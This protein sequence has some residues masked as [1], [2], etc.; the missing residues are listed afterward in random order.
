[1]DLATRPTGAEGCAARA[2]LVLDPEAELLCPTVARVAAHPRPVVWLSGAAVVALGRTAPGPQPGT[3]GTVGRTRAWGP[4]AP[5]PVARAAVVVRLAH[6]VRTGAP[7]RVEVAEAALALLA[8]GLVPAMAAIPLDGPGATPGR[9]PLAAALDGTGEVL[10]P[11]GQPVPA[12]AALRAAGLAPVTLDG[13]E[14]A[15]LAEG[16][17]A[18]VAG[19]ALA[20][21]RAEGLLAAAVDRLGGPTPVTDAAACQLGHARALVEAAL[22]EPTAERAPHVGMAADTVNATVTHL[23]VAL[24]PVAGRNPWAAK[25][26][27]HCLAH[28]VG[29]DTGEGCGVAAV[30]AAEQVDRLAALL[31]APR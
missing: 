11:D 13:P 24:C 26:R 2:D 29:H 23:A 19:T 5:V 9:S 10:G 30:V 31:G 3:A 27:R 25:M 20:V 1:M 4:S 22:N 16:I 12:G 28:A 21:A 8:A 14:R 18:A 7:V 15:A 17:S 6:L